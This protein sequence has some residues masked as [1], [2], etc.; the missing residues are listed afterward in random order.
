VFSIRYEL[1][2]FSTIYK[3]VTFRDE[4]YTGR[5]KLHPTT[6]HEGTEEDRY[7][8]ALSLNCN[9]DGDGQG[10]AAAFLP[11]GKRRGSFGKNRA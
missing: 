4:K 8:T 2:F 1:D 5:G 10:D 6:S 3:K 11:P 7:G 9:L